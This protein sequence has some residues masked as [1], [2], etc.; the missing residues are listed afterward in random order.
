LLLSTTEIEAAYQL[1]YEIEEQKKHQS[2]LQ[3]NG[4]RL[5]YIHKEFEASALMKVF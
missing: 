4:E 3:K 2:L 5:L 1:K